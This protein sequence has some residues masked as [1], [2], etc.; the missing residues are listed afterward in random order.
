M[1]TELIRVLKLDHILGSNLLAWQ[2]LK[3]S[4]IFELPEF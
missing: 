4:R 2:I 1:M 3:S